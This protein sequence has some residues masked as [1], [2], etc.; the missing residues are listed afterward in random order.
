MIL[1]NT[2]HIYFCINQNII[3]IPENIIAKYQLAHKG[4]IIKIRTKNEKGQEQYERKRIIYSDKK[5]R[6]FLRVEKQKILFS[7]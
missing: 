5:T 6:S 3:N 4:F 1:I 2:K 7:I